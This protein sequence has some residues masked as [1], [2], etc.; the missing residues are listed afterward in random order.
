M[1]SASGLPPTDLLERR[2]VR[3]DDIGDVSYGDR[4]NRT[5]SR[6]ERELV[7]VELGYKEV[8]LLED[9]LPYTYVLLEP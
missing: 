1:P 3:L 5:N 4:V 6:V 7:F 2:D 8:R 9:V